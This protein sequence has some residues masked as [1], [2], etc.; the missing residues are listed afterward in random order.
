MAKA[1]PTRTPRR[2]SPAHSVTF[3]PELRDEIAR[4]AKA[5]NLPF[6]AAVRDL[7]TQELREQKYL[8]RVR[9]ARAWQIDQAWAE[10]EAME[11]GEWEEASWE[12][13]KSA[14][15]QALRLARR[16]ARKATG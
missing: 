6:G 16:K 5:R 13:V 10:V 11:R 2:R 1:S 3:P 4:Y 15:Q 12:D 7:V 8:E 14:H 9:R